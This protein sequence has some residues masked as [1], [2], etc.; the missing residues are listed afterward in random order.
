M[1]DKKTKEA[2]NMNMK[3]ALNVKL[4]TQDVYIIRYNSKGKIFFEGPGGKLDNY[5]R[6]IISK[7]PADEGENDESLPDNTMQQAETT[8]RGKFIKSDLISSIENEFFEKEISF[9]IPKPK[10][11]ELNQKKVAETLGGLAYLGNT[12]VLP[13]GTFD[14]KYKNGGIPNGYIDLKHPDIKALSNLL[15]NIKQDGTIR[16]VDLSVTF[17]VGEQNASEMN[18]INRGL[19]FFKSQLTQMFKNVGVQNININLST[20]SNISQSSSSLQLKRQ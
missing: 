14:G 20:T 18:A 1:R 12:D 13:G 16:G 17:M 3:S 8:S 9:P 5:Y 6:K 10:I 19:Q 11:N 15:K 2:V 4:T 7:A